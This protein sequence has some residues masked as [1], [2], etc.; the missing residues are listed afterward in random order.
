MLTADA[1]QA[2]G[3]AIHEL[4]TNAVKYGALSTPAGKIE[5]A[6]RYDGDD[7]ARRLLLEW[8]EQGGPAIAPPA[9]KGFGEVVIQEMARA[10]SADVAIDFTPQGLHCRIAIPEAQLSG[11]QA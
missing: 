10:L 8:I 9:Q 11:T 4:A 5:L 1:A 6:W 2:L 7:G 3:L